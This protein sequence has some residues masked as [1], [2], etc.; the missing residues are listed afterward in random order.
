MS[1]NGL[2]DQGPIAPVDYD[3]DD[4]RR[5]S[6][7]LYLSSANRKPN[8]Q[9]HDGCPSQ[10]VIHCFSHRSSGVHVLCTGHFSSSSP[11]GQSFIPSHTCFRL[12]QLLKA[13]LARCSSGLQVYWSSSQWISQ[14]I[15]SSPFVQSRRPSHIHVFW[16]NC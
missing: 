15:S 10:V 9:A 12:T 11:L 1:M 4:L 14:F 5:I 8:G 13:L 3:V 2:S 6:S 16:K 7:Y